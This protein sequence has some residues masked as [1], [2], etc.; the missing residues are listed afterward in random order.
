MATMLVKQHVANFESWKR[1]F[2]RFEALRNTHG[3]VGHSI[4][5]DA[6]DP[7]LIVVLLHA[8]EMNEAKR[9][10]SSQELRDAMRDAGVQGHPEVTFLNE[11]DEAAA[12]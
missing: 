7:N 11:V 12:A 2:D 4:H 9:Y 5:R 6:T 10:A 3:I 8:K 1:V